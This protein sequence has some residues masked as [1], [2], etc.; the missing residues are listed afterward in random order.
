MKCSTSAS[1]CFLFSN[2][3]VLAYGRQQ[4][5]Y[6]NQFAVY[7]PSGEED[8]SKLASKHGFNLISKV[9]LRNSTDML[10]KS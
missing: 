8:A 5:V 9:R 4:P 7:V 1:L 10:K 3:I 6:M 2:L